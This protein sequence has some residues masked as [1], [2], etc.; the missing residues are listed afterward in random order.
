[1][2]DIFRVP[3]GAKIAIIKLFAFDSNSIRITHFICKNAVVS[4]KWYRQQ[5]IMR[6]FGEVGRWADRK[7]FFRKKGK[8]KS[9]QGQYKKTKRRPKFNKGLCAHKTVGTNW[10]KWMAKGVFFMSVVR[11][12]VKS[13]QLH[14]WPTSSTFFFRKMAQLI[15]TIFRI[16]YL[17]SALDFVIHF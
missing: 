11:S 8:L 16:M 14:Y 3:W 10:E 2:R 15:S 6:F 12:S 5:N 4:F 9:F 13:S 1:M 17:C 7:F